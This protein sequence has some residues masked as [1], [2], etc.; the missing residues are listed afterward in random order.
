MI[1]ELYNA[2]KFC[3]FDSAYLFYALFVF[4]VSMLA[5]QAVVPICAN[6]GRLPP[7]PGGELPFLRSPPKTSVIAD[8]FSLA[9][10]LASF[11]FFLRIMQFAIHFIRTIFLMTDNPTPL[12]SFWRYLNIYYLVI[13]LPAAFMP[14][15]SH[16]QRPPDFHLL[17]AVV[18]LI[19]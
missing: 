8:T 6:E 15:V 14:P 16:P 19:C 18:L 17:T 7:I 12:R 5:S 9:L 10:N 2:C 11:S 13:V 4:A 3:L 1:T